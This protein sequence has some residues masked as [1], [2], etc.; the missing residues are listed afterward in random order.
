MGPVSSGLFRDLPGFSGIPRDLPGFPGISRDFP[1]FSGIL[2]DLPGLP[3]IVWASGLVGVF[4]GISGLLLT[5]TGFS[6][7]APFTTGPINSFLTNHLAGPEIK[8]IEPDL[9]NMILGG[10]QM[11]NGK[12][13]MAS[14]SAVVFQE[15]PRFLPRK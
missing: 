9:Q 5:F 3:G 10:G 6:L 1:G 12:S 13:P 7:Q 14:G 11:A 2:R 15:L 8:C 4:P